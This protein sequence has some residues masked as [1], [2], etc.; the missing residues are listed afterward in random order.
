M[1]HILNVATEVQNSFVGKIQYKT[2]KIEDTEEENILDHFEAT[3]RFID[4]ARE[5]G[6]VLVHCMQ[7]VSRS[8]AFTM[9]YLMHTNKW[10]VNQTFKFIK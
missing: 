7:G 6:K 10:N 4:K 1:T 8:A 3:N 2:I 5:T 9:A